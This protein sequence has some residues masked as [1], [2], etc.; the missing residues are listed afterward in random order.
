[1]AVSQ[2]Y[3]LTYSSTY[4]SQTLGITNLI[5][6]VFTQTPRKYKARF[7]LPTVTGKGSNKH[8]QLEEE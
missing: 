1:M 7:T 4:I 3:V 8:C 6:K 5:E 2:V